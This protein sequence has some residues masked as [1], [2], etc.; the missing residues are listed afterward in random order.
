MINHYFSQE[1]SLWSDINKKI[2]A[3]SNDK[4][5]LL[6]NIHRDF[7]FEPDKIED[8]Q[9]RHYNNFKELTYNRIVRYTSEDNYPILAQII[10]LILVGYDYQEIYQIVFLANGYEDDAA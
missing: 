2:D 8:N 6:Y 4:A 3:M 10:D 5:M 9:V 1:T 7:L